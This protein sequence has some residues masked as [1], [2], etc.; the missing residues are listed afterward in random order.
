M[1]R[2]G[3]WWSCRELSEAGCV[4]PVDDFNSCER[5]AAPW[6]IGRP[7]EYAGVDSLKGRFTQNNKTLWVPT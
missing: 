2:A 3:G 7:L 6:E 1:D 5:D 4:P